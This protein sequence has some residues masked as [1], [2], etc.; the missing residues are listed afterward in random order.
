MIYERVSSLANKLAQLAKATSILCI[1][2][3]DCLT[4]FFLFVQDSRHGV[5]KKKEKGKRNLDVNEETKRILKMII[6]T[7]LKLV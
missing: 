7:I 6:P 5:K 1:I 4:I 3:T 2:S